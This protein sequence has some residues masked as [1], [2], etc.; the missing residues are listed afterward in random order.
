MLRPHSGDPHYEPTPG[1]DGEISPGSFVLIDLWAKMDRPR[2]VYSDLTRVGFVGD[3]VPPKYQAVF[4]VVADARDAAI[5]CV[6][7]AFAAG[8]PL[9]GYEVDRAAQVT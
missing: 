4:K 1:R 5:A 3:A 9:R 8:R 2:A 6:R 7:G